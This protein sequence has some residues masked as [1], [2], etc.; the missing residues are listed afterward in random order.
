MVRAESA[1]QFIRKVI[2]LPSP[3][4]VREL[5]S[6]PILKLESKLTDIC[7]AKS[8]MNFQGSKTK[9]KTKQSIPSSICVGALRVLYNFDINIYFFNMIIFLSFNYKEY[10]IKY[11]CNKIFF[12]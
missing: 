12:K 11:L 9:I 10:L 7:K 6:I 4:Y 3:S 5:F 8:I 1:Y 2:P